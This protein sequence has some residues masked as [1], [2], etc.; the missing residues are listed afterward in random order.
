MEIALADEFGET[1][2]ADFDRRVNRLVHALRDAGMQTGDT[3]SILS[4]NRREVF[5]AIAA[6]TQ[7]GWRYVPVNWHW[8]DEEVAYVLTNSD[9][10]AILTDTRFADVA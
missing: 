9:S 10:K 2:W 1:S 3:L 7:A 5:E 8:V 6:A 4:G